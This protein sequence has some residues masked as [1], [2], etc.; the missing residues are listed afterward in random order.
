MDGLM[1]VKIA[2]GSTGSRR[3]TVWVRCLNRVSRGTVYFIAMSNGILTIKVNGVLQQTWT[4]DKLCSKVS[5]AGIHGIKI[6][7]TMDQGDNNIEITFEARES[8]KDATADIKILVRNVE[9]WVDT[10]MTR[11]L[12]MQKLGDGTGTAFALRNDNEQQLQC[13]QATSPDGMCK[14]WTDCMGDAMKKTLE[15]I[16]RVVTRKGAPT[17][18]TLVNVVKEGST[19]TKNGGGSAYNAY[20]SWVANSI[21]VKAGQTNKHVRLGLTTDVTDNY[22]FSNGRYV[23]LFPNGRLYKPPGSGIRK[24]WFCVAR[25]NRKTVTGPFA[26]IATAKK[27]LNKFQGSWA[28]R[29]MICEMSAVGAKADPHSVGGGNQG[30]GT[31]AGFNKMWSGWG[32]IKAMN[33]MCAGNTAC[34]NDEK[35]G[36]SYTTLDE[37]C[38]FAQGPD[39]VVQKNGAHLETWAGSVRNG[40]MHAKM[41]F[42]EDDSKMTVQAPTIASASVVDQTSECIDP[43][44]YD[45]EAAQCECFSDIQ[46]SCGRESDEEACFLE[47]VCANINVCSAWKDEMCSASLGSVTA[48]DEGTGSVMIQRSQAEANDTGLGNTEDALKGDTKSDARSASDSELDGTVKGKCGSNDV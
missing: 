3:S 48:I 45:P 44:T 42:Y 19:Y 14:D 7:I 1:T 30:G 39:I 22:R 46:E 32:D 37:I 9:A 13:L 47:K 38:M 34:A 36:G 23:G 20:A 33:A 40:I 4:Q 15:A 35:T 11:K 6:D 5:C 2:A 28:N 24:A 27:E 10:C 41:F 25:I 31:K 43:S 12:C 18:A 26:T 17:A 16:L 8:S 21:C 29:Q